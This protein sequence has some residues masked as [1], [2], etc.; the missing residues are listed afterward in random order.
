MVVNGARHPSLRKISLDDLP[1]LV[2][3]FLLSTH[4]F[5][6][7][8]DREDEVQAASGPGVNNSHE[9][10]DVVHVQRALFVSV[11]AVDSGQNRANFFFPGKKV[12]HHKVSLLASLSLFLVMGHRG[13]ETATHSLGIGPARLA[14]VVVLPRNTRSSRAKFHIEKLE[15]LRQDTVA[16]L[17]QSG[18]LVNRLLKLDAQQHLPHQPH[19]L[20]GQHC[21]FL[22]DT[23][24]FTTGEKGIVAALKSC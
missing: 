6:D 12:V 22:E 15:S 4:L 10:I 1:R 3:V 2:C 5:L 9:V 18:T 17:A 16:N 7:C 24:C 11:Q 21:T 8:H 19:R 13:K 14:L 23:L 20:T